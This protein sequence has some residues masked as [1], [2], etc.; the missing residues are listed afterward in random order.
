MPPNAELT[1]ARRKHQIAALAL[2]TAIAER[3]AAIV[4]KYDAT[5]SSLMRRQPVREMAN[6]DGIYPMQKRQMGVNIGRDL[7]RNYS[8]ARSILHQFRMNV[9]GSLGKLQVNVPGGDAAAEWFNG[10]WAKDCDY[11]DPGI[12]FSVVLQNI[13]ASVLREGDVL[14]MVDDA[15]LI[16][17][18]DG[19]GKLINW[20]ADQVVPLTED[21]LKAK[22]Y[23]NATQENG[24]IRG[25]WGKVEAYVVTGKRGVTSVEAVDA[26]VWKP[27]DARLIKNPW[28]VNQGRG[29]PS[30]ITSATNFLDLYEIL[31]KELISAKR[32]TQIAGYVE[33][34]D[35]VTDW[36][37]PG[38]AGAGHLPE[39][40]TKSATE[41]A[42]EGANSSENATA[43]YERFEAL[44]GGIFEYVA[45]GDK[46]T[47]P[48]IPRP[49]VR[50]AEFIEAILGYAGASMGLASAYTLL[51]AQGSYTAFRGDMMLSW[52][53]FYAA[54]KWLERTYADW[55]AGKVLAWAQRT[56]AIPVLPAGW[57]R[58]MS[59]QWPT[60]PEVDQLDAENATAQALKNGTVDYSELLGPDWRKR[61]EGLSEQ[62]NV[63][64]ELGIPLSV[65]ELKSGGAAANPKKDGPPPVEQP[66]AA[67]EQETMT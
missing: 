13:V 46:I 39:N 23:A 42:A 4:S 18:K 30:I 47:F 54:Q 8:P 34:D 55:V 58:A 43:N 60:M 17:G 3:R 56:K 66:D 59:W 21:G 36:D 20:E 26:T 24:I 45:K 6:E 65:L 16:A 22:G 41:T 35:S 7:E 12:H 25:Q 67:A 64:R 49:N 29:I 32:A 48:D 63:I 19:S 9:V 28:R 52:V 51:K 40:S 31:A 53:T 15:G 5:E 62:I 37:A 57:E 1:A 44:T 33:R 14:A 38:A 50:L 27:E 10:V 2:E 61:L 11:R